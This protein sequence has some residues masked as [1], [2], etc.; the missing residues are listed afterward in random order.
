MNRVLT[1]VLG[2][3]LLAAHL[4]V[5][6]GD[7]HFSCFRNGDSGDL[8]GEPMEFME[9]HRSSMIIQGSPITTVVLVARESLFKGYRYEI[10]ELNLTNGS[11]QKRLVTPESY[12]SPV[13]V[14]D[15]VDCQVSD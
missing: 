7:L 12:D 6:A 1:A 14:S 11:Y 8:V 4:P 10:I 2:V 15:T 9:T 13:R 5:R 3:L